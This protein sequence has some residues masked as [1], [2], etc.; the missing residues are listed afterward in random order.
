[1]SWFRVYG[2]GEL[3][4]SGLGFQWFGVQGL[5]DLSL[6]LGFWDL[7]FRNSLMVRVWR[8]WV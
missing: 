4:R 7:G 1:M 6:T 3:A 8:A 5:G 2:L